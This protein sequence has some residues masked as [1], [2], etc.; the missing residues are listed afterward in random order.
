MP[1]ESEEQDYGIIFKS[2][3]EMKE[4][5]IDSRIERGVRNLATK[6][7]LMREWKMKSGLSGGDLFRETRPAAC[8]PK[9]RPDRRFCWSRISVAA[10]VVVVAAVGIGVI[11]NSRS[12]GRE[13]MAFTPP[14]S[15]APSSSGLEYSSSSFEYRGGLDEISDMEKLMDQARYGE[16]IHAIDSIQADTVTAAG[17][18]EDE[19]DYQRRYREIRDY[20]LTWIKIRCLVK[21]GRKEEAVAIL[22]VYVNEDGGHLTE[23]KDLLNELTE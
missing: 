23:A 17:M 9:R 19:R 13:D 11:L 21:S 14:V 6:K 1:E 3:T 8:S 12:T 4:E 20:N 5:D 10:S 22:R 15:T 18:S 7:T 2:G 16:A